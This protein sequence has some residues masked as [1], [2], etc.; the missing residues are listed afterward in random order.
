MDEHDGVPNGS[1]DDLDLLI[2]RF[3]AFL[4]RL[5]ESVKG[6]PHAAVRVEEEIADAICHVLNAMELVIDWIDRQ[7]AAD[8]DALLLL[9][10][11]KTAGN[12]LVQCVGA[13]PCGMVM[14]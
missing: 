11:L 10:D 1:N 5:K 13:C 7:H 12:A 3:D 4:V 6:P 2:G 14:G 8:P 9:A